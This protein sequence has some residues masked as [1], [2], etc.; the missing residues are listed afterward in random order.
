M[1]LCY[2]AFPAFG[3]MIRSFPLHGNLMPGAEGPGSINSVDFMLGK[4]CCFFFKSLSLSYARETHQK[5]GFG[6]HS[7]KH[8]PLSL[9]KKFEVSG[10]VC[11]MNN[12]LGG[13]WEYRS[14]LTIVVDTT[15]ASIFVD[16]VRLIHFPAPVLLPS[17]QMEGH[18]HPCVTVA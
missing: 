3:P 12:P 7:P 5:P 8:G 13:V 17:V 4:K 11:I 1:L 2:P 10:M 14:H 6:I 15:L 9:G 16:K 18:N